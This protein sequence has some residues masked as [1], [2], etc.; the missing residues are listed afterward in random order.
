MIET[1]TS[2]IKVSNLAEMF[3]LIVKGIVVET[4]TSWIEASNL[5]EMF[6]LTYLNRG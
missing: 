3:V 4:F 6:V 1:F 2:R 5:A